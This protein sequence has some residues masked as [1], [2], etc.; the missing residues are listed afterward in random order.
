MTTNGEPSK[1]QLY[2]I[3]HVAVLT[4]FPGLGKYKGSF[5]ATEDIKFLCLLLTTFL[6]LTEAVL[7]ISVFLSKSGRFCSPTSF[8]SVT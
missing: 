5:N 7:Y 2:I 6:Y 4:G 3:S 1:F 8:H